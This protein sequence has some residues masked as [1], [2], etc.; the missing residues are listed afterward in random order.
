MIANYFELK[1]GKDFGTICYSILVGV[2][3][4]HFSDISFTFNPLAMP[5]KNMI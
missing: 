1:I 4:V 3:M 2:L 5:T